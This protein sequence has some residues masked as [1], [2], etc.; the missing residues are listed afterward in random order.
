MS[1]AGS[2]SAGSGGA[3]AGKVA[4]NDLTL[5]HALDKA[6][7]LLMKACATGQHIKEGTLTARKAGRGQQEYLIIKMS[8]ILVTSVQSS[9]GGEQPTES[10]SLQFGKVDLAY[11]PQKADGSVDEGVRFTYDLKTNRVG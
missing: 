4:F 9:G 3:G 10:V 5:T 6:S 11:T 7:P 2:P 8:D 1:N